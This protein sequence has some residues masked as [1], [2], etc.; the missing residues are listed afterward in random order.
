MGILKVLVG[1]LLVSSLFAG[2]G[3][4]TKT[5]PEFYERDLDD[6]NK[7]VII[8][9]STGDR[10]TIIDNV[11]INEFLSEIKDIKFIPEK[12][13]EGRVGWRYSIT[14]FHDE[15]TFQFGLTQINEDYYYTE[16]DIHPIVDNFYRDL[17]VEE[18]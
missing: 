18:E 12:N 9:G 5:L 8:D 13:Q 14:L 1:L 4:E 10:K 15:Q 11:V 3:L 6:V 16:P 2:C 7:I 17:D